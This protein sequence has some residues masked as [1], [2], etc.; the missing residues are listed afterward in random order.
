MNC[1]KFIV[2]GHVQGVFYRAS[3]QEQANI[4]SITGYAKNLRNGD[5]EV[6]AC[7]SNDAIATLESWL[8]QGPFYAEVKNVKKESIAVDV[9]PDSF[10]V[11]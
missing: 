6:L 8:W 11:E 10:I 5:V 7:G 9:T 1:F 3:T 2:S 4:L